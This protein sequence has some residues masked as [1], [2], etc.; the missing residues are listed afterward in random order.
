MHRW[1]QY[2]LMAAIFVF[3][4]VAGACRKEGPNFPPGI[5]EL[6]SPLFGDEDIAVNDTLV[7]HSVTDPD[8]DAVVYDVYFGTD[9]QASVIAS[10]G[11]ADTIFVPVME[12]GTSY[13]WKVVARDGRGGETESH[14]WRFI[15]AFETYTDPRDNRVYKILNIGGQSWMA[16]NMIYEIPGKEITDSLLWYNNKAFD[17]WCYYNNDSASFGSK[18]GILYQWGAAN[19]V[20]P[21]GWH[22]PSYEE[23]L[24]LTDYLENNG[25][26]YEGSGDD[27]SKALASS[28]GWQISIIP[29]TTGYDRAGNN[30]SGFSALPGGY[31]EG[32]FSGAGFTGCWWTSSVHS[33]SG[34]YT[35]HKYLHLESET[36]IVHKSW[37][38]DQVGFSAR[39]LKD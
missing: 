27:I 21:E 12:P 39:C 3:L 7:W 28:S 35:S 11:Q 19:A 9:D 4:L 26:G 14:L 30:T 31:R 20:C 1:L 25:Y 32:S 5:V 38:F 34:L 29:G 10:E 17:G 8:F 36:G 16:E 15:T 37:S 2:S 22:L 18:Y 24:T 6:V 13:F 23:W 33:L